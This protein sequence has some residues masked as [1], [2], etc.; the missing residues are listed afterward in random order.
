MKRSVKSQRSINDIFM[1][2]AFALTNENLSASVPAL[3]GACT[4]LSENGDETIVDS[5]H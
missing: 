3:T 2:M 4:T 5:P 1:I